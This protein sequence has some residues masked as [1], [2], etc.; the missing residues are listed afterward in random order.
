MKVDPKKDLAQLA[1]L[2]TVA[3]LILNLDEIITKG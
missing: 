2:T 1:S 3:T